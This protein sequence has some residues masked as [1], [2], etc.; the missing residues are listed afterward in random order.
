MRDSDKT[1]QQLIDELAELRQKIAELD[2][3]RSNR[4]DLAGSTQKHE[5]PPENHENFRALFETMD[6][7]II[8]GTHNGKII[9]TNPAMSKKLVY[10]PDEL[11]TM[12]VWDLHPLE[13]RQE[14][15]QIFLAMFKGER[16]PFNLP[17]QKK[18]GDFLPVEIR[19]WFGKWSGMD[20][21]F[22]LCKDISKEQ[23]ALQK[24]DRLFN[25]NPVPMAV[26]SLPERKFTEINDS[27]LST[28]GFSRDEIIGKTSAEIGAFTEPAIQTKIAKMLEDQGSVGNIEVEVRK[29]D[30]NIIHGLFSGEMIESQGQKSFLTVMI[31]ITQQK[32]AENQ[33]KEREIAYRTLAENLPGLVYR[34]HLDEPL[35]MEFFNSML[36]SITGFKENEL[37]FGEVC[38]IETLIIEEDKARVVELVKRA[39]VDGSPFEVEYR[40]KN[41]NGEIRNLLE[42]GRPARDSKGSNGC[43]DGVI[44]DITS[45]KKAE[46][47]LRASEL[48]FRS[49]FENSLDGVLFSAPDGGILMANPAACTILGRTEKEFYELGRDGIVDSTETRLPFMFDTRRRDGKVRCELNFKHRTGAIIP[50]ELTSAIFRDAGNQER[51]ITVFRDITERKSI[52]EVLRQSEKKYRELTEL[53][54]QGVFETDAAGRFTFVNT[55]FGRL[56]GY[57]KEELLTHSNPVQLVVPEN[58]ERVTENIAK[59]IA[60]QQLVIDYVTVLKKDGSEVPTM[61]YAAPIF[62]EEKVSGVRGIVIDIS[63]LKKA[64]EDREKLKGQLFQSQKIEALGTLV[65][66][67][68]HDFNNMLQIIIGY[69]DLL[70]AYKKE[71]EPGYNDLQ[72]IIETGRGGA[73]LVN[74]LL[75]FGQQ[76]QVLP[77]PMNLNDQIES[78]NAL[79]SRTL[80][81]VAE[82]HL[83]LT[84][85]PAMIKADKGLIDQI[86]MNLAINASE[87]MPNGGNLKIATSVV[88]LDD[89]Y[90]KSHLGA[91]PG[92]YVMLSVKDNGRGI[93]TETLAKIFDPFF[94]TKERGS[95]RGTG[96]GLSVVQGI[97]QQQ[98]GHITCESE[99]GKGT[100]FKVYFPAIE[101]SI[102]TSKTGNPPLQTAG[103]KTIL[104][105]EDNQ[106]VAKLE[107]KFLENDGYK[108]IVAT[109]GQEALDIY[110]TGREQISMV[111]LD[112]LMPEMSGRDCLMELVKINPSVKVLI[113]SGYVPEDELR[114][115]ISPFVKGFIHKPFDMTQFLEAIRKIIN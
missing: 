6:E 59:M 30:G 21:I 76:S 10:S 55:A 17:F 28:L 9:Y 74:K 11:K 98:G 58:R 70:L 40:I 47:A 79:I 39:L 3:F 78:M 44:F 109:N 45:R 83:D 26:S 53:L 71:G 49:M 2:T 7:M 60:G 31:D 84:D 97:V 82:V 91:K 72:T 46:E 57:S 68:A 77:V 50:V 15:E 52:E 43:I 111:I 104:L 113:A 38:S 73:E 86:V 92:V 90:C 62:E 19:A 93:N 20:C 25:L 24:F 14:A 88:S 99:P 4:L 108:V 95:T 12:H 89:G 1:K 106:P 34:V 32:R 42:Y 37:I 18:N 48:L 5:T 100:E 64:E 23:E 29:K 35:R 87:A 110:Q 114:R 105:V 115:E 13:K 69:C 27:F 36:S 85:N 66:G 67:I 75:A 61:I 51:Y 41:K 102:C 8:V 94:S 80:P 56:H 96:L 54:P 112:L 63:H 65:G 101:A 33:L 107:R 16:H 22:G 81:H 103:A